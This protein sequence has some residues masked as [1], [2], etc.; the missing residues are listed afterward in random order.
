MN[1]HD[2]A[3]QARLFLQYIPENRCA[4]AC[5]ARGTTPS[6]L[7]VLMDQDISLA[8]RSAEKPGGP[9]TARSD[10]ALSAMMLPPAPSLEKAL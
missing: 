8:V 5:V 4:R 2:I 6:G 7:R 3:R 1:D 10:F 9:Y